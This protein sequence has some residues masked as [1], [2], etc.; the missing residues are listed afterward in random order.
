M[1]TWDDSKNGTGHKPE[2]VVV[3][4]TPPKKEPKAKFIS[5]DKIDI[6]NYYTVRQMADIMCVTHISVRR[7]L[8]K[9][10]TEPKIVAGISM[11]PRSLV[12]KLKED[13]ILEYLRKLT[14]IQ[15]FKLCQSCIER[16]VGTQV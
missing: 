6:D 15:D 10:P 1:F 7:I 11:Y 14:A 12:Y 5:M 13:R 16:A 3:T 2:A 9:Y 4:A 8:E